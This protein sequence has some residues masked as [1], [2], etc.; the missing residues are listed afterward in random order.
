MKLGALAW[1]TTRMTAAEYQAHLT[2]I[3]IFFGAVLGFVI[4]GIDRLDAV[5]F[6]VVLTL[7]SGVVISILYISASK[8]RLLY[9]IY[10]LAAVA[11]LP[12]I[13]DRIVEG[14][15]ELPPKLQPTLFVWTFITIFAEFLPREREGETVDPA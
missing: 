1:K 12:W 11:A 13:V 4:N 5:G 2:G 10:T 3:N 14:P 6:G 15:F 8:H 7:I 9:S